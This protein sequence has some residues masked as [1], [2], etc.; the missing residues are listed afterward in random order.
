MDT[1]VPKA[2][3]QL[4]QERTKAYVPRLLLA[5]FVGGIAALMTLAAVLRFSFA[6]WDGGYQLHP[7]ERSILYVAEDIELGHLNPFQS[8]EGDMRLYPYGHLP[9]YIQAGVGWALDR[10]PRACHPEIFCGRLLNSPDAPRFVHLTY[11]GRALSALYDVL[12]VLA[13]IALT[14]RVTSGTASLSQPWGRRLQLSSWGKS[15]S[16]M[17]AS[18]LAGAMI[19]FAVLHIQNAHFGTVDTALA[20]FSTLAL[21]AMVSHAKT[22]SQWAS[23]MAG[24]W[25]G[26]AIGSKATGV[27]LVIPL[28]LAHL[29]VR[30][31]FKLRSLFGLCILV[32]LGA[33]VLT[34]PYT[35]LDPIPFG[36]A[37]ATQAAL[38]RGWLDWPFIRQYTGTLPIIYVIEQQARWTLGVPLTAAGY[39]GLGWAGWHAWRAR[40]RAL[41]IV[42]SWGAAGLLVV[43][44]QFLKF[45]RYMLLF[46]PTLA[47]CAAVWIWQR[48]P[49]LRVVLAT[50]ILAPTAVYAVAFVS[51]YSAPHPWVAASEWIYDNISADAVIAVEYW[52][53]PLPLPLQEQVYT[54]IALDPF[55]EPDDEEKL[56]ALMEGVE[57]SDYLILSSN[58]L[59]GAIPR[60]G[61]RYPLTSAYYRALFA[62]ELDFELVQAFYRYPNLAGV[63][64]VDDPFQRVGLTSPPVI[65]PPG[66]VNLGFADESFTVYDH[67]LVLIFHRVE[68]AEQEN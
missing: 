24:V 62:G 68:D 64:L 60:L 1:V 66:G 21:G 65:W 30:P 5:G 14:V 48:S 43:G 55:S 49:T 39:V 56:A 57:R 38:M 28:T 46:T 26:L 19:T 54:L 8:P 7:D 15:P 10:L 50:G 16:Y 37:W 36:R 33:F 4:A 11:V 29:E 67:P 18:L 22:G 2:A 9:L 32:A 17:G 35:I 13:T 41:G 53:D 44:T 27:L 25:T 51:M 42:A 61:E 45:P 63:T 59:Y 58:R 12:T 6:D 20:L 3:Q 52:D 31:R 47:V 23:L 40:D 34:N